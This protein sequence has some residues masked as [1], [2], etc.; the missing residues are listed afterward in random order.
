M[1]YVP[2]TLENELNVVKLNF[3]D[4][5]NGITTT[6]FAEIPNISNN[7]RRRKDLADLIYF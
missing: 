5:I 1:L 4:D 2:Q 7:C 3:S 6:E